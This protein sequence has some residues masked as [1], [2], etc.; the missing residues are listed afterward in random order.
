MEQVTFFSDITVVDV[1]DESFRNHLQSHQPAIEECWNQ[2]AGKDHF[3]GSLLNILEVEAN[4]DNL[5]LQLKVCSAEYKQYL[6]QC[7][8][9]LDLHIR[10]LAVSGVTFAKDQVLLGQRTTSVTNY[11]GY[12]ELVP[13]GS[14]E[15][16]K[17]WHEQIVDELLGESGIEPAMIQSC[18]AFCLIFDEGEKLFDIGCA[19]ELIDDSCFQNLDVSEYGE[20][21]GYL[22]Q[23]VKNLLAKEQVVPTSKLL[24]EAWR[25]WSKR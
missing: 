23:K 13:S 8:G 21:K 22:L 25:D 6:A 1:E 10:P 7:K 9:G 20:M 19:I 5:A 4:K 12:F 24:F 18:E 11:P 2:Y 16:G 15:A 3:N 17:S 14:L